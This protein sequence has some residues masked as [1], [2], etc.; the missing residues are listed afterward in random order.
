M[1]MKTDMDI[2]AKHKYILLTYLHH[3]MHINT[4]HAMNVTNHL[5]TEFFSLDCMVVSTKINLS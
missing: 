2:I 1:I 3:R 4:F 5:G